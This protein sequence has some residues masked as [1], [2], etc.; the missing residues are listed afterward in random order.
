MES[1]TLFVNLRNNLELDGFTV[2]K[3]SLKHIQSDCANAYVFELEQ[4]ANYQMRSSVESSNDIESRKDY[5]FYYVQNKQEQ[6]SSNTPIYWIA[7]IT[8]DKGVDLPV[9]ALTFGDKSLVF[10]F[11]KD[12]SFIKGSTINTRGYSEDLKTLKCF[13]GALGINYDNWGSRFSSILGNAQM[14]CDLGGTTRELIEIAV[15][16]GGCVGIS[17]GC[18]LAVATAAAFVICKTVD[19]TTCMY[20]TGTGWTPPSGCSLTT[21]Y[22]DT[23]YSNSLS[24]ECTSAH[25]D[26]VGVGAYARYA[27]FVPSRSGNY[28]IVMVDV[29]NHSNCSDDL[30]TYLY[31]L[32]ASGTVIAYNDDL[33]GCVSSD[34]QSKYLNANTTYYIETTTYYS[35][36]SGNFFFKIISQ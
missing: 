9:V 33:N 30:D 36:R 25:R 13:L 17:A 11:D 6:T 1:D 15:G 3:Q 28:R 24:S 27:K 7:S 8:K 35:G 5:L 20:G 21:V 32:D 2:N 26:G 14:F 23:G 22:S 12:K 10:D 31:L 18:P 19:M 16:L 4:N 29:S 34:I